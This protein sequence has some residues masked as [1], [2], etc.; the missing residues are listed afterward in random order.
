MEAFPTAELSL[1]L[2]VPTVA[3]ASIPSWKVREEC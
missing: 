2:E 1:E 3:M